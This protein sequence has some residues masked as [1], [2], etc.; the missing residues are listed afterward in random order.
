MTNGTGKHEP[1]KKPSKKKAKKTKPKAPAKAWVEQAA[2]GG[3]A[4]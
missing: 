3:A 4:R 1:A 2:R